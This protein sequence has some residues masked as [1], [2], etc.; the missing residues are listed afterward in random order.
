MQ[1]QDWYQN[2]TDRLCNLN[3]V[4]QH[5][6][7]NTILLQVNAYSN[8]CLVVWWYLSICCK[9]EGCVIFLVNPGEFSVSMNKNWNLP[10]CRVFAMHFWTFA[11]TLFTLHE[12]VAGEGK[13]YPGHSIFMS[14]WNPGPFTI[15]KGCLLSLTQ[16][17][18]SALDQSVKTRKSSVI[19]VCI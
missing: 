16:Q 17:T 18:I 19:K 7:E 12:T 2:E 9:A 4:K 3:N 15:S 5:W 10:T 13:Q 1:Q 14:D 6:K 8:V 11:K